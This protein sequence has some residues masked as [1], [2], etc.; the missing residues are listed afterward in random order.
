MYILVYTISPTGRVKYPILTVFRCLRSNDLTFFFNSI[1]RYEQY[2]AYIH[3]YYLTNAHLSFPTVTTELYQSATAMSYAKSHLAHIVFVDFSWSRET[4]SELCTVIWTR[5]AFSIVW[6]I[7][8]WFGH[9]RR[10][11]FQ[12]KYDDKNDVVTL[13]ISGLCIFANVKQ[14][15]NTGTRFF[16]GVKK[17]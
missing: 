7:I 1:I 8:P 6:I 4:R 11:N 16:N 14:K 3:V 2:L 9:C 17:R 12:Y 15:M 10:G 13:F 5:L